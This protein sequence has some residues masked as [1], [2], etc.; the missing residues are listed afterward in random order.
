MPTPTV[1]SGDSPKAGTQSANTTPAAL[2][3]NPCISA[4]VQNDPGSANNLL[5]GDS[6]SQTIALQAG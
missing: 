1:S 2:A 4:L 5:V 6:N 3:N